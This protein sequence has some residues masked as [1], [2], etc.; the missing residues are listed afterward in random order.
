MVWSFLSWAALDSSK[1]L[2]G[3]KALDPGGNFKVK[4]SQCARKLLAHSFISIV[5]GRKSLHGAAL[6]G[7]FLLSFC[8]IDIYIHMRSY[9]NIR[10]KGERIFPY[11]FENIESLNSGYSSDINSNQVN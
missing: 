11:T 6:R 4:E 5:K 8:I 10:L 7:C 9:L 3:S 2:G 1:A